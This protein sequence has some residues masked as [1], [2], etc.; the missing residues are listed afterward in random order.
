MHCAKTG[1]P[2]TRRVQS[3]PVLISSSPNYYDV[4]YEYLDWNDEYTFHR[5]CLSTADSKGTVTKY[6][7]EPKWGLASNVHISSYF[8][9]TRKIISLTGVPLSYHPE[10]ERVR[11]EMVERG[12]IWTQFQDGIHFMQKHAIGGGGKGGEVERVIVD[13]GSYRAALRLLSVRMSEQF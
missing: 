11:A 8:S 1:E 5:D 12:K 3:P 4:T 6:T 9:G 2:F 10:K 13:R 7:K